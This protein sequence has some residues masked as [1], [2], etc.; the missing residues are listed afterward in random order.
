MDNL[1]IPKMVMRDSPMEFCRS[2]MM[3]G[4]PDTIIHIIVPFLDT[5]HLCKCACISKDW[6][7][8]AQQRRN[9]AKKNA[10]R[11]RGQKHKKVY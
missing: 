1:L 9:Q 11:V 10:A 6:A 3:D 4:L 7:S 2:C 8:C 5:R